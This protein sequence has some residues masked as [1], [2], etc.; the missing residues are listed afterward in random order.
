MRL[1]LFCLILSTH[2]LGQNDNQPQKES[3]LDIRTNFLVF[4]ITELNPEKV[5][6]LERTA[7]LEYFLRMKQNNQL[8]IVKISS[9]DGTKLDQEFAS[10]FLKCQYELPESSKDCEVT[11]RL[12]MKSEEQHICKKDEQKA[13][14]I[15]SLFKRLDMLF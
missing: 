15:K 6:W 12:K 4:S 5:I 2:V 11:L 1:F 7:N 10:R 3:S 8:K 9:R 13:Q 14:E